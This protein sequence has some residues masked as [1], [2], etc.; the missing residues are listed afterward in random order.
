MIIAFFSEKKAPS[1]H[2]TRNNRSRWVFIVQIW[3]TYQNV[4]KTIRK[5]SSAL[6][7]LIKSEVF[8]ISLLIGTNWNPFFS[9]NIRLQVNITKKN[10]AENQKSRAELF[11][12]I[13]SA[14]FWYASQLC[15]IK[16]DWVLLYLINLFLENW[17]LRNIPSTFWLNEPMN[18]YNTCILPI[19][20]VYVRTLI[21]FWHVMSHTLKITF[22][23]KNMT[24][25]PIMTRRPH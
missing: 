15:S 16:T 21:I 4:A 2:S 1:S 5:R 11:F 17:K 8:F 19:W 10:S 7:F 3:F 13:F 24:F 12:L 20:G 14:I 23:Q 18:T 9:R 6:F 25:W 22:C